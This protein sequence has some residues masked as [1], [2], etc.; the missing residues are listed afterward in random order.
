MNAND[1][2]VKFGKDILESEDFLRE[3]TYLSHGKTTTYD[4]S[5][6]V[7][8]TAVKVARVLRLN[9]DYDSLVRGCLLHDYYLYDWHELDESHRLHGF[10][11]GKTASHNAERD[12]GLNCI[13][14]NMIC[15]HMFPLTLTVPRYKESF[16]VG[17]AD[18]V[19]TVKETFRRKPW[20]FQRNVV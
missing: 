5:V 19:C 17:L 12:F 3:R 7:A 14:Q 13:E 16:L 10:K 15:S 1:I 4:H 2:V 11:H 20:L 8:G 9:V 18:K 6:R